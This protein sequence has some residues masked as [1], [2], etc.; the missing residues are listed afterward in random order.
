M[1]NSK[2]QQEMVG[3][4]LIV[5][6]VVIAMMIFLVFSLRESDDPSNSLEVQNMLDSIFK[7]TTGCAPVFEPDYDDYED[8][9]KSCRAGGKCNNLKKDACDYLNESLSDVLESMMQTQANFNS[10]SLDFFVKE[11]GI[12]RLHGG[13]CTGDSISALKVIS[14]DSEMLSVKLKICKD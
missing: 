8:L 9:F 3:F 1:M 10:Y 5:I 6:I 12:L 11:E 2:A 14:K 7:M 13:N 4:V